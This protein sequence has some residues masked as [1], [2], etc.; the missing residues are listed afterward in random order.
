MWSDSPLLPGS[1]FPRA[2]PPPPRPSNF[3]HSEERW[4]G[5]RRAAGRRRRRRRG[6]SWFKNLGGVLALLCF[7]A[8]FQAAPGGVRL[9]ARGSQG[10]ALRGGTEAARRAGQGWR[11]QPGATRS[12]ASAPPGSSHRHIQACSSSSPSL[13]PRPRGAPGPT[14][15]AG[16]RGP[17]VMS[18]EPSRPALPRCRAAGA[19]ALPGAS[20]MPPLFALP[21]PNP[22]LGLDSP[23]FSRDLS[24]R[25]CPTPAHLLVLFPRPSLKLPLAG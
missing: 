6:R 5:T 24:D 13:T 11:G 20:P 4:G 16:G 1:F 25:H 8:P 22:A 21:P 7:P 9:R 12:T 15:P 18:P 10:A 14:H 3:R 23:S 17:R 19:R 2:P